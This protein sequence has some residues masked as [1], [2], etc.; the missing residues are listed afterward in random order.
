M[1]SNK[2]K[3]I[4]LG[5]SGHGM[6]LA[7]AAS[8]AGIDIFGYAGPNEASSNPYGLEF[9][10]SER[11]PD[12]RW[13]DCKSYLLGVG[14]NELRERI[15]NRVYQM[16]GECLTIIH[17]D[18]HLAQKI[19][20][21]EGTFIARNVSVNPMVKIG[22]NVILNTSCSVDH[23][24]VIGDH[25]HIAPGAVLAG[26][27]TVNDGAFVGANAVLKEGVRIGRYATIGAGSVVTCHV[28]DNQTVVGNPARNINQ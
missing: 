26:S 10:G 19:T 7:E 23:E 12:F 25:V 8:L 21:D 13:S 4:L 3:A 24:C 15:A 18:S 28:S 2:A 5:Y 17:P 6:V 22:K 27:V 14:S 11:K 1:Q 16:G 20:V 9:L